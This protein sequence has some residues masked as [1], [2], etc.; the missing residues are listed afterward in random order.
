MSFENENSKSGPEKVDLGFRAITTRV[1]PGFAS[2]QAEI[3]SFDHSGGLPD[4]QNPECSEEIQR[5]VLKEYHAERLARAVPKRYQ[6]GFD[7]WLTDNQERLFLKNLADKWLAKF[8]PGC[9][10][11]ILTHGE[12][13]VGKTFLAACIAKEVLG[14]RHRVVWKSVARLINELEACYKDDVNYT[15][16]DLVDEIL[17]ADLIVLDDLGAERATEWVQE[18]IYLLVNEAEQQEKTLIVTTNIPLDNL[19]D[20]WPEQG[21]RIANRICGICEG[22]TIWPTISARQRE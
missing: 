18:K 6:A 14:K 9:Q 7:G 20:K 21:K 13:G 2:Q 5:E 19:A 16:L 10:G 15:A 4:G 3:N 22:I 1:R 8:R 17:E 12:T 11:L